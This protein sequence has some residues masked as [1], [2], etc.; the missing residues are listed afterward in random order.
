[1]LPIIGAF[2]LAS[3]LAMKMLRGLLPEGAHVE[4]RNV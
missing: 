3:W 2:L 1:M 4:A